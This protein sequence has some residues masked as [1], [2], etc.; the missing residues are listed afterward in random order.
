MANAQM[1]HYDEGAPGQPP[2]HLEDMGTEE[3]TRDKKLNKNL[4]LSVS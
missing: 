1:G 3:A 4:T 2:G